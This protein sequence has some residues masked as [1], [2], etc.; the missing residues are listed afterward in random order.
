[1]EVGSTMGLPTKAGGLLAMWEA[2][3]AI[4]VVAMVTGYPL[5][6]AG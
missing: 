1:M 4:G 5:G 2:I 6:G 3:V